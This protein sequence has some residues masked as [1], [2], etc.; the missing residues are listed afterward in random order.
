MT[1]EIGKR[2]V[3]TKP[4]DD[5]TFE[6]GDRLSLNED[7]SISNYNVRGWI[8]AKDVVEATKGMEV[9]VDKAWVARCVEALRQELAGLEGGIQ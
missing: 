7:G 5:G 6:A 2:Y 4:S 9:E 8:D 1:M 3:V